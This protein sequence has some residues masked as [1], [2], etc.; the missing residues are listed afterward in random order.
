[1]E[2]SGLTRLLKYGVTILLCI[3]IAFPIYWMLVVALTPTGYSRSIGSIVPSEIT[4]ENFRSL[5][6]ERPMARWLLNSF[7]LAAASSAAAVVIG[8]SA[9]YVISRFKFRGSTFV[10]L[11]VLVSQMMPSTSIIVPLYALFRN[12]GLLNTLQGVGL[13]HLTLTL[14]L[15]IWMSKGFFDAI[16][17]DLEGAALI[18]GCTQFAAFRL[19]AL[20]LAAP[21]LAAIFIY[22]FITSWHEFLFARTLAAPQ[23]LWTAA[24]GLASFR[25]EFFSMFEPQMAAAVVFALPVMTVF[26]LLQKQ[27]VSGG[28]GG[29]VK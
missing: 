12:L 23:G 15:A 21:G 27:F 25:G 1:M 19:V 28:L 20:P 26:F 9:G 14:P 17:R 13:A 16:P 3:A 8:T 7:I 4:F 22:G 11:A 29:G 24:V 6:D 5:F 10:M 2:S 18:D